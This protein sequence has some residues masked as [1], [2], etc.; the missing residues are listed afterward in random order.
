MFKNI[1]LSK[2]Y[3]LRSVKRLRAY[4]FFSSDPYPNKNQDLY[5]QV[6]DQ[7]GFEFFRRFPD[8]KAKQYFRTENIVRWSIKCQIFITSIKRNMGLQIGITLLLN[9][10]M[11]HLTFTVFN[12]HNKCHFCIDLGTET[13]VKT[14]VP[15]WKRKVQTSEFRVRL[16][17][18]NDW[19]NLKRW[20]CNRSAKNKPVEIPIL[21]FQ[22]PSTKEG[23][24]WGHGL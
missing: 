16:Y 5:N 18:K 6:K 23:C 11:K 10:V 2:Q 12:T 8:F 4:D 3:V 20:K 19:W 9:P 15:Q 21:T 7:V 17:C 1:Y 14:K 22:H 13:F 24:N